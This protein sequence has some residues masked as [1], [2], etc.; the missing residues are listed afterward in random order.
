MISKTNINKRLQKKTNSELVK[1]IILVKKNNHLELAKKLSGPTKKQIKLNLEEIK[2]LKDKKI[3]VPGKILGQGEANKNISISA[4]SFS[5]QA[6][7]KLEKAGCEINLISEEIEKNPKLGGVK[8]IYGKT[9][10]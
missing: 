8:I 6:K 1:T 9:N 4:L 10:N 3:M 5:K 7:E 2:N